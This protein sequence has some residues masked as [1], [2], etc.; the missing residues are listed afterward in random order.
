MA[1]KKENGPHWDRL[2]NARKAKGLTQEQLALLCGVATQKVTRWEQHQY[3]PSPSQLKTLSKFLGVSVDWLIG[4][5]EFAFQEDGLTYYLNLYKAKQLID[6]GANDEESFFNEYL[7]TAEDVV[8]WV[9]DKMALPKGYFRT[10]D[11]IVA[12]PERYWKQKPADYDYAATVFPMLVN[13]SDDE[14]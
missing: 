6:E 4:N 11:L 5:D 9:H 13:P 3:E 10:E 7:K 14:E 1:K 12:M 8:K 2:E